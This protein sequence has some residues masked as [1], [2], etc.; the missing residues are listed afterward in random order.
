MEVDAV[1]VEDDE[2]A[3]NCVE[4]DDDFFNEIG[5]QK[6]KIS[7]ILGKTSFVNARMQD[8]QILLTDLISNANLFTV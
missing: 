7:K 6:T 5:E 1:P 8:F 2:A 4:L 3:E